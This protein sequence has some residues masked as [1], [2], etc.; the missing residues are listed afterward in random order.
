M[1]RPYPLLG[2]LVGSAVGFLFIG[3]LFLPINQVIALTAAALAVL[4]VLSGVYA[5]KFWGHRSPE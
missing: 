2:F 4:Y 1:F 5:V 3:G